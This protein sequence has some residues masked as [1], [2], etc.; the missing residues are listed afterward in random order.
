MLVN[1][2]RALFNP[3]PIWQIFPVVLASIALA[4]FLLE[5]QVLVQITPGLLI[6]SDVM[7]NP[8]MT[9]LDLVVFQEPA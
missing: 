6:A 2:L 5:V 4:V 9:D 1:N 7:I 3:S 8:L